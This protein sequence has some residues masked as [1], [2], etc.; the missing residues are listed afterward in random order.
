M[1]INSNLFHKSPCGEMIEKMMNRIYETFAS[2][3]LENLE[4]LLNEECKS[5][6]S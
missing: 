4:I 6:T 5:L 1:K 2:E 3:F